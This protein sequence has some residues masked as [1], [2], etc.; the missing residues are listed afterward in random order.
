[1]L[2]NLTKYIEP[3]IIGL[4]VMLCLLELIK[5]R[6]AAEMGSEQERRY[7]VLWMLLPFILLVMI[8]LKLVLF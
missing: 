7:H 6:S 2:L 1:M 4:I 8:I 3:V 5:V